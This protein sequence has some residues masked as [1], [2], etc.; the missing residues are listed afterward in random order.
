MLVVIATTLLTLAPSRQSLWIDEA[1]I[2]RVAMTSGGITDWLQMTLHDPDSECFK[3]GYTLAATEISHLFGT[4]EYGFRMGNMVW[5]VL[6]VTALAIAGRRLGLRWLPLAFAV[7]PF[8]WF[9]MDELRPYMMQLAAASWMLAALVFITDSQ[10]RSRYRA[11]GVNFFWMAAFFC[12]SANMLGALTIASCLLAVSGLY[13]WRRAWPPRE[14][15]L[16]S[17]P[18]IMLHALLSLYYLHWMLVVHGAAGAML[19]PPTPANMGFA[20]YELFGF[21]GFGPGRDAIREVVRMEGMHGLVGLMRPYAGALSGFALINLTAC[22]GIVWSWR[23]GSNRRWIAIFAIIAAL[24]F[25]MMYAGALKAGWPFWGR[26]L[27]PMLPFLLV[28]TAMGMAAYGRASRILVPLWIICLFLGAL[29]MRYSGANLKDDY[30]SAAA[31]ANAALAEGKS[32][33]WAA[34][35]IA[36]NFYNLFP[37]TIHPRQVPLW[38][39][40]HSNSTWPMPAPVGLNEGK[41]TQVI[42]ETAGTL[43]KISPPDFII[44]SKSDIYDAH[45]TLQRWIR[46]H[47]YSVNRRFP[48]F[49]VFGVK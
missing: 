26:H 1:L 8:S 27:A 28:L 25:V 29:H 43:A 22:V 18:W 6:A 39:N 45:G 9:Y 41:V 46:D 4:S 17:A 33:W 30:R 10:E 31:V 32:V 3:P 21:M 38:E 20:A 37:E 13:L 44:L 2:A 23:K 11:V 19:W 42:S 36:A 40:A 47:R 7:H 34:D 49:T 15:F 35:P 12:Y 16:W 48:S 24:N 14:V 5:G